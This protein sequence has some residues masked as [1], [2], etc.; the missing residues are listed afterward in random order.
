MTDRILVI[1]GTGKTGR[2]VAESLKA[3]KVTFRIG[4]RNPRET[5]HVSFDW[6][7]PTASAPAF[8]GVRAAYVVAPTNTSDHEK[9]VPPILETALKAGVQRFVLLS[10]SSL[11]RGG[12]MMGQVHDWL[13]L[14]AREWTVLRPTWF[15]QNFSEQQHL[16]TIREES[17]IYSATG[18]GRV[19]FIDTADIAECAVAALLSEQSANSDFILTGPEA[20]SYS[21]VAAQLSKVLARKIDHVQLTLEQLIEH[22]K[23]GGLPQEYAEI[24]AGMDINISQGSENRVT[25]CVKDLTGR[26]PQSMQAFILR[27]KQVW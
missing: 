11:E 17:A 10:A 15:M 2:Y 19:G 12:P 20:L 14:N 21:D 4:T 6:M 8:E 3:K 18:E 27:E 5:N 7:N 24:L 23:R 22:L 26:A 16:P 9:V 13:A 25:S 1:G